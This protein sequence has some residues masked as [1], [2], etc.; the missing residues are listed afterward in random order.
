MSR[1]GW[2]LFLL[3]SLIWGI[4]YLLIRIAVRSIDPGTLLVFRTIPAAL[5]LLPIAYVNKGFASLRGRW[6][7]VVL[8]AVAEF[9]VP[10]FFMG[11]AEKHLTS[12]LTSL[13]A[14]AVPLVTLGINAVTGRE[15]GLSPTRLLGVGLGTAGVAGLVGF[16]VGN[17][18]WKYI[19]MMMVVVLGYSVGPMILR[20]R[21]EG[22]N[23]TAVVGISTLAM[24]IIWSPWAVTH[25]PHR[26]TAE[27]WW[28]VAGLSAVCTAVAFV[29]FFA[30]VHEV[31]PS[32]SV[33]VTFIN[34]AVAVLIGVLGAHESLTTGI[35]LGLPLIVLGSV[36]ATSAATS[37][38]AA[39][40]PSGGR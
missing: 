5:A 9:G 12:S 26:V 15:H 16:N 34:P 28:S 31:G 25:W 10:W 29:A 8:F 4:P 27:Q 19:A 13:L 39:V 6:H 35:I 21:L 1:R 33:V 18:S 2:A 36:L 7:W 11:T 22:A 37:A 17:G 30:L 38:K 32:R 20:Y 14:S 3:M 24:G 40:E 23:G